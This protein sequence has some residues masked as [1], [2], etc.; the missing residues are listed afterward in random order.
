MI[1]ERLL[2]TKAKNGNINAF[3][4][5][6][7]EYKKMVYYFSYDLTGNHEDAE[8]LSQEVFIKVFQSIHSFRSEGKLSSWLYRITLNTF[9]S[10]QRRRNYQVRK[11][12]L[13]IHRRH[14]I[15]E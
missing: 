15:C 11:S 6:V 13:S 5:L 1:D 9:I 12:Q 7:E 2:I 3:K 4:E 14:R 10:L 8:D